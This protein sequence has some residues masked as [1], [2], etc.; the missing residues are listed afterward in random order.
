MTAEFPALVTNGTLP[1][2]VRQ[3]IAAY[4]KPL[5]G[6]RVVVSIKERKQIRSLNQNRLYWGFVLPPIVQMF[7][8]AGNNV[9]AE[10]VHNYLKE[11]VGKFRQVLVTGEGEVLSSIGSTTRL[12]TSEFSDYV[13]K[14]QAWA[15][16]YGVTLTLPD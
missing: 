1:D 4:L 6:K 3:R 14:V 11:H 12:T 13:A 9:D 5:D 10:D 15:V 7:R 8:D 2:A 16:E